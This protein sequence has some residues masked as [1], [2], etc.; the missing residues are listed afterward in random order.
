[1][2]LFEKAEM[3]LIYAD[4]IMPP[5]SIIPMWN[6]E[7]KFR[8]TTPDIAFARHARGR[9]ISTRSRAVSLFKR[10]G[11]CCWIGYPQRLLLNFSH[12]IT[13]LSHYQHFIPTFLS[14]TLVLP[15]FSPSIP[16]FNHKIL[17]SIFIHH[18]LSIFLSTNNTGEHENQC[19]G[20]DTLLLLMWRARMCN[21]G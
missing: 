1:M 21:K 16:N 9:L 2:I 10:A 18:H 14:S 3:C 4:N 8:S 11:R 12:Y 17:F 7:F 19:K 20:T 5:N 15:K 13:F 6:H